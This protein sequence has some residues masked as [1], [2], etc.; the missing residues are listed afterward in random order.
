V[1]ESHAVVK[2]DTQVWGATYV[3]LLV[4]LAMTLYVFGLN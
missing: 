4:V 2:T 1:A 3:V